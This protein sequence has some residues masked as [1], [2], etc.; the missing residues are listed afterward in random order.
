MRFAESNQLGKIVQDK[1]GNTVIFLASNNYYFNCSKIF[2][3]FNLLRTTAIKL[4]FCRGTLCGWLGVHK[5]LSDEPFCLSPSA[6]LVLEYFHIMI[7][8]KLT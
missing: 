2:S 3:N 1:I 4:I 8:F 6:I 7:N 5:G